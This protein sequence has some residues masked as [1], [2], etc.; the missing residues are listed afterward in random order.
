MAANVSARAASILIGALVLLF[1]SFAIPEFA[2]VFLAAGLTLAFMAVLLYLSRLRGV[3]AQVKLIQSVAVTIQNEPSPSFVTTGNSDVRFQNIAANEQF[4]ES[5]GVSISRYLGDMFANPGTVVFRLQTKASVTGSACEDIVARQGQVRISVHQVARD[6]YLWRLDNYAERLAPRRGAETMSLPLL[7]ASKSGTILFMNEACR[8]LVGESPQSLDRI[9]NELPIRN[10]VENEIATTDGTTRVSVVELE[11]GGGRRDFYLI[12]QIQG[13]DINREEWHF[14]DEIPVPLLKLTPQGRILL[15]NRMVRDLLGRDIQSDTIVSDLMEG[16][17]RPI[18]DWLDEASQG[19][20]TNQTEFLKAKARHREVF[21]QVTLSRVI[22]DGEPLLVAVLNDATELKSLEAQF[23]QSQKM[24]AIGQLAGGIAHDFNNLLT[25]ISGHCDLLL[26]RHDHGDA[27][28]ADLMQ[29]N[30]NANRAASLVGQLLA[31][32]R[33]QN[34]SPET[35]DLGDTLSELAHLLNRLVGEKVVLTVTHDP[36]LPMIRADKRQLEQ[37]IMNLVVNA[38]DAM[39]QG[40]EIRVEMQSRT[41]RKQLERDRAVVPKGDYIVIRVTDQG[42]GI[43][44][45]R[46]PK[47]FEPFFTTKRTGE[48]TGLGLSTAY[49]IV[50]QTGGF[51]F[52]DSAI[53][54]GTCFSIYIPSFDRPAQEVKAEKEAE[55]RTMP[56]KGEGVILLVEDEAPVRAFA[57]R[58]LRLRGYTVLEA[59]NGEIALE[60]LEDDELS[61]DLFVSDVIMPGL[62]G[63]TWVKTALKSRPET[64]VVFMSGYAEDD[65]V[66]NQ[67]QIANSVFLQKPFSLND[68]TGTVQTLIN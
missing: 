13:Q 46:L 45:D 8:R 42:T 19:R 25:A 67:Q 55:I 54:Y 49:G 41:L 66:G 16:L 17:G 26:L 39:P 9:F 11:G 30:Q 53:G 24:Q 64:R 5:L 43:S 58:A 2:T 52:A 3:R 50:K 10:G 59:E 47:I 32:S 68:L 1:A 27:G 31:F 15:A 28:F 38:R 22:E 7:T 57:S 4:S 23:V 60:M 29:I 63:P 18:V 34:L 14:F 12:P 35:I 21:L 40:G 6:I 20:G 48:G 36:D 37:V 65:F 33:K 51:I 56:E 62:D 44:A 61:V